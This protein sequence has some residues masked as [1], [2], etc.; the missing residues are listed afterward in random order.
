LKS[1][2]PVPVL[3]KD[4]GPTP[5]ATTARPRKPALVEEAP[6]EEPADDELEPVAPPPPRAQR[7]RPAVA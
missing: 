2:G 4:K 1:Y 6:V 5:A 7:R 3:P